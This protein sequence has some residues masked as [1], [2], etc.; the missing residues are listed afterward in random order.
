[1]DAENKGRV[2]VLEE[3]EAMSGWLCRVI[4]AAGH[5]VRRAKNVSELLE[6]VEEMDPDVVVS[7][8][9]TPAASVLELQIALAQ[10]RGSLPIIFL[11]TPTVENGVR[12]L[13]S[14]GFRHLFKPVPV[15]VLQETVLEALIARRLGR[16]GGSWRGR[17]G[18]VKGDRVTRRAPPAELDALA[19]GVVA[20]AREPEPIER[21]QERRTPDPDREAR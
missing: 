17:G 10:G 8:A 4:A 16:A 2:V 21:I 15:R 19:L 9:G 7:E 14:G 12:A 1:M 18:F 13:L 20:A 5:S 6:L 3:D 11:A